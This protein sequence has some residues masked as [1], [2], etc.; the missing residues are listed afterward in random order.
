MLIRGPGELDTTETP[1]FDLLRLYNHL[2]RWGSF[3]IPRSGCV[4]KEALASL[5]NRYMRKMRNKIKLIVVYDANTA[6]IAST[7]VIGGMC[8]RLMRSS[9]ASL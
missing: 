2:L 7:I 4:R 3:R 9:N 6:S 8:W 1:C 5:S